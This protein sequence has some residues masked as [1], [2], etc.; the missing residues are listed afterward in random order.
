MQLIL[1]KCPHAVVHGISSKMVRSS[2]FITFFD[3][4]TCSYVV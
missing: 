4:Y 2:I 1:A 3:T